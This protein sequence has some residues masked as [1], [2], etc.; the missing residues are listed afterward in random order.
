MSTLTLL[1][2]AKW[3]LEFVPINPGSK[4]AH[5]LMLIMT[6]KGTLTDCTSWRAW[7]IWWCKGWAI[8]TISYPLS[9]SLTVTTAVLTSFIKYCNN[10]HPGSVIQYLIWGLHHVTLTSCHKT[11]WPRVWDTHGTMFGPKVYKPEVYHLSSNL[12]Y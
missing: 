1:L 5:R 4:S 9:P 6:L 3:G 10:L 7:W 12:K 8:L 11:A 2:V